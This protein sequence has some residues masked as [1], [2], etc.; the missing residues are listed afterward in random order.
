MINLVSSPAR[1][2]SHSYLHLFKEIFLAHGA[3]GV[4]TSNRDFSEVERMTI[5]PLVFGLIPHGAIYRKSRDIQIKPLIREHFAKLGISNKD[6]ELISIVKEIADQYYFSAAPRP[7]RRKMSVSDL[8]TNSRH[9]YLCLRQ[10]QHGRCGICGAL[11]SDSD[12]HLDH[13]IPFRLV[14]DVANGSNWQILCRQCNIGKS[15]WLSA[16]QP[17]VSQN[18]IYGDLDLE[19][20]GSESN[21][22]DDIGLTSRYALLALRRKCEAPGCSNTRLESRL[23]VQLNVPTGLPILDNFIVLCEAHWTD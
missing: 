4:S 21:P 8:R 22:A 20:C 2:A 17:S 14:G 9:D 23:R 5:V 16:L 15:S 11:L 10:M 19:H 3:L 6:E 12:E 13:K 1:L 7:V 18:W